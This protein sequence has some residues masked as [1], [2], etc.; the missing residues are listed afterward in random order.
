MSRAGTVI[1]RFVYFGIV[2]L[3]VWAPFPVGS[4][5]PF[6]R[7]VIVSWVLFLAMLWLL[8]WM[9]GAI[10]PASRLRRGRLPLLLMGS[11]LAVVALQV[12]PLSAA[13]LSVLS[14][15]SLQAYRDGALGGTPASLS[16]S[17]ARNE[18]CQYLYLGAAYLCLMALLF[19]V[20]DDRKRLL[21]L[22]LAVVLSG[23]LQAMFG[24]AL[25]FAGA[26]YTA[27][28]THFNHAG[29]V[30][31]GFTNRNSLA[32]FLEICLGCGVGLMVAQFADTTM[33]SIKQRVRW[34][35]S[36]LLSPKFLLRVLLV[37]MVLALILTRSRMGNG[38][39]FATTLAAGVL[40][41][42]LIRK[43]GCSITLF[44]ASMIALDVLVI[45]SWFGVDQVAKRIEETTITRSE[46]LR[47][48]AE[49][50]SLEERGIP[51]SG[52]L[53]AWKDFPVFGAGSGAFAYLYTH[54]RPPFPQGFYD[55]AHNDYAEFLLE[56]GALGFGILTLLYA[57]TVA[58]ALR[59]MK[60]GESQRRRGIAMGCLFALLSIAI[61][62]FVDMP[63]Q[64][65]ANAVA[66]CAVVA[67]TWLAGA[68]RSRERSGGEA[69]S[70]GA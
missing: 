45:G 13:W 59:A 8:A 57:A 40:G 30:S 56:G 10:Q 67:L 52:A 44:L 3:I 46:K 47:T 19:A 24:I 68:R 16:I 9:A 28:F 26:R 17:I 64:I 42:L 11:W 18:T 61:H 60:A 43:S 50:E 37:V 65:P 29:A 55:H 58:A 41:L 12:L 33:R 2:A 70:R 66:M 54:Y 69:D 34:L 31:G 22:C 35:M 23:T 51:A 53:S 25:H 27:F 32:A 15:D 36:L 6:L 39:F 49:E 38:A 63:L 48:G 1:E 21:G 4:N 14:P 7:S 5:L 20:V 62:M